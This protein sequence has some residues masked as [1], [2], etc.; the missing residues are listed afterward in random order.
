MKPC[1]PMVF[2]TMGKQIKGRDSRMTERLTGEA[3]NESET[4]AVRAMRLAYELGREDQQRF[5]EAACRKL[6]GGIPLSHQIH[7]LARDFP[8]EPLNVQNI[9]RAAGGDSTRL[10]EGQEEVASDG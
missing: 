10:T 8:L 7:D 5:L 6:P 4:V 2:E 1:F 9:V 3:V